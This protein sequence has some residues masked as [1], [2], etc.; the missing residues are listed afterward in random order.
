M[1]IRYSLFENVLTTDPNDYKAQIQITGSAD[2]EMIAQKIIERGSTVT[3]PDLLAVFESLQQVCES[4]VLEGYRVNL[5]GLVELYPRLRGIFNG[6]DDSYDPARHRL[7]VAAAP[8]GRLR[9]GIRSKGSVEKVVG[10]KP[11]PVVLSY[12][13]LA[14]GDSNDSITP[15]TIGTI[16]GSRLKYNATQPDEGI[17]LTPVAGGAGLKVTAV[18]KN[19]PSELIFLVPALAPGAYQLEVRARM[20]NGTELRTGRL[21]PLLTA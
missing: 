4:L 6:V 5:G 14:T 12:I 1:P 19:K 8:G 11:S 7:D 15:S 18:Q 9:Q 16:R 13:D 3:L 17:F 20:Q 2:F 21:D 10:V